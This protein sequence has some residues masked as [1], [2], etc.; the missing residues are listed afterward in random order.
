M[1]EQELMSQGAD[2]RTMYFDGFGGYRKINGVLRCIGF[3]IGSGAQLNLVVSLAGADKAA[4]ATRQTL[5]ET[6]TKGI[7]I[8]GG[9]SLAH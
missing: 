5:D 4:V 6:A 7:H 8:W 1:D 9:S 3:I 2:V